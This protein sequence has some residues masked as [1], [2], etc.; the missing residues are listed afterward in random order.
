MAKRIKR[1]VKEINR[2]QN[3]QVLI[4]MLIVLALGGIVLAP[5]LN[6]AATSI[7]HQQLIETDALELYAAD[8][9][10]ENAIWK[11][12]ENWDN[13]PSCNL[14]DIN[15]MD[16]VAVEQVEDFTDTENGRLYTL[17]STAKLDGEAK[18]EIVAEIEAIAGPTIAAGGLGGDY[19]QNPDMI[20]LSVTSAYT[21]IFSTQQKSNFKAREDDDPLPINQYDLA[22]LNMGTGK[23]KIYRDAANI[24]SVPKANINGVHY[25]QEG[26]LDCLLVTIAAANKKIGNPSL[27]QLN[28]EPE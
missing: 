2:R 13:D 16:I 26:E 14:T 8:A 17:K 27:F 23:S 25:Y 21:L 20:A 19:T 24:T 28:N 7:K 15:G 4:I 5:T 6:H 11:L 1:A 18:T 10:I 9:G 22:A 12:Q 3:G